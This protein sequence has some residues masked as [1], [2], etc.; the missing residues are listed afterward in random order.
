MHLED[1][2]SERS[3]TAPSADLPSSASPQPAQ[4]AEDVHAFWFSLNFPSKKDDPLVRHVL[5]AAYERAA[6]G[7]L[8]AWAA[9]SP[10]SWVA[11][12]LLLDQVPRHLY[13][14]D[15]RAYATDLKAQAISSNGPI[16]TPVWRKLRPKE[17]SQILLPWLHAEDR[18]FQER[19]HPLFEELAAEEPQLAFT[20]PMST[21][22]TETIQ[23]FGYFPHRNPMRGRLTTREEQ[24]Y[25]DTI[26][27]PRRKAIAS[28][29]GNP[30]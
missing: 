6:A 28:E 8:D 30:R 16:N 4:S 25:L 14:R 20:V 24:T 18:T 15:G 7:E 11:L 10:R 22:Y 1:S 2:S 12:I 21:L 3:D 23:R 19:V 26:W 29:I 9:E 17:R 27:N 5:F 13:R